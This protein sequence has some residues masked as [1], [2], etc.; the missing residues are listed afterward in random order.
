MAWK[1]MYINCV[2]IWFLAFSPQ[3]PKEIWVIPLFFY[4]FLRFIYSFIQR[5]RRERQRHRQR[6]KQAPCRE[7]NVGLDPGSPGSHP[8]L[9]VVLNRCATGA[10]RVIPLRKY[11]CSLL[12]TTVWHGEE[13]TKKIFPWGNVSFFLGFLNH[14]ISSIEHIVINMR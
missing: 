9:Q 5:Q 6:E 7:P 12:D 14:M 2:W 4:F 1:V 10:A 8:R 11:K 13:R 3:P